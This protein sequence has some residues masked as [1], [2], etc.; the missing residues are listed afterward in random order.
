MHVLTSTICVVIVV[1]PLL[2]TTWENDTLEER[3]AVLYDDAKELDQFV[4]DY[5]SQTDYGTC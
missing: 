5:I 4:L 1:L 3:S 2:T